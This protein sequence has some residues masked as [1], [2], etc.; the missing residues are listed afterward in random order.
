MFTSLASQPD[1]C[2]KPSDLPDIFTA[3]MWFFKSNQIAKFKI[4]SHPCPAV[5]KAELI[6]LLTSAAAC[7]AALSKSC[8]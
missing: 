6:L 1:I 8:P 5:S 2:P 4:Y 7:R 3:W